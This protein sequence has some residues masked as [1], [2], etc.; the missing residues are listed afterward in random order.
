MARRWNSDTQISVRE[1]IWGEYMPNKEPTKQI[2]AAYMPGDKVVHATHG[3]GE[4][5]ST[6]EYKQ[7]HPRVTVRYPQFTYSIE[8][9]QNALSQ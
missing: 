7:F 1:R 5:V 9:D 8:C 4:V 6:L 2:R 3:K